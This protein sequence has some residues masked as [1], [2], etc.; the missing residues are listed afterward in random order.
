VILIFFLK[1]TFFKFTS[2]S[3]LTGSESQGQEEAA[4][5]CP[6]NTTTGVLFAATNAVKFPC[7]VTRSSWAL[8]LSYY[9]A[10]TFLQCRILYS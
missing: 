3:R 9:R 4:C 10:N 6:A 1:L 7:T 5:A 2:I 8:P